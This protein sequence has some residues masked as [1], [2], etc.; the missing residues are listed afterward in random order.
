MN[1]KTT[2]NT[3]RLRTRCPYKNY[4]S[5]SLFSFLLQ[6]ASKQRL[7]DLANVN[8]YL[9]WYQQQDLRNPVATTITL[10]TKK[11]QSNI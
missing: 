10:P 2:V 3:E 1:E 6:T 7:I 8:R 9:K 5:F 11:K 4:D